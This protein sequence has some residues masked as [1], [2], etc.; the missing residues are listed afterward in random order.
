MEKFR[1]DVISFSST[2]RIIFL[3]LSTSRKNS[4][5]DKI[6]WDSL[7]NR[8]ERASRYKKW[9]ENGIM[10]MFRGCSYILISPCKVRETQDT[11]VSFRRYTNSSCNIPRHSISFIPDRRSTRSRDALMWLLPCWLIP[12]LAKFIF[13]FRRNRKGWISEHFMTTI[14]KRRIYLSSA[15]TKFQWGQNFVAQG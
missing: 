2:A 10:L 5:R 15:Y 13:E 8:A 6:R 1:L 7:K 14:V 3:P 4:A 11:N 12:N 9:R